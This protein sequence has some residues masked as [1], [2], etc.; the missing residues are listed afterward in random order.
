MH[1][2]A[3]EGGTQVGIG[4]QAVEHGL[5]TLAARFVVAIRRA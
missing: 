4:D 3:A 2:M 1:D 5:V